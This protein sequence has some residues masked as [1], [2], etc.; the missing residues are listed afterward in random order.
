MKFKSF[1]KDGIPTIKPKDL[2]G[3]EGVTLIDVRMPEEYVGELGHIE[4]TRLITLGPDLDLYLKSAN[5]EINIV[6]ICRSSARSGKA[7]LAALELGFKNIF[8]MEG[9][10]IEWNKLDLPTVR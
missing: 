5:K 7:S 4:G 3:I 6:F 9:G 8:N 10:M 2:I 1:L